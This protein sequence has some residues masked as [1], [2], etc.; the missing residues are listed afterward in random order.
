ML[1]SAKQI[2]TTLDYKR[3]SSTLSLNLLQPDVLRLNF[4]PRLIIEGSKEVLSW[5]TLLIEK[6]EI[7]ERSKHGSD[8]DPLRKLGMSGDKRLNLQ[9]Q[10]IEL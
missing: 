5:T 2:Y 10:W 3:I 1:Y 6:Q 9:K 4:A 8:G 7:L